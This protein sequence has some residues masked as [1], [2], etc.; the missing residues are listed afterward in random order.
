MKY[1]WYASRKGLL[2][3][4][5]VELRS[6]VRGHDKSLYQKTKGKDIEKVKK[7]KQR[8]LHFRPMQF[9]RIFALLLY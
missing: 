5:L 1:S 8:I 9:V 6:K 7:G 4:H 2:E 3:S